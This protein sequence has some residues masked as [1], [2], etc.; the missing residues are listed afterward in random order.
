[1]PDPIQDPVPPPPPMY[2]PPAPAASSAGLS[3]NVAAALAYVTFFPA[4]IFLLVAPYNRIALVRFHSIQ[5]IALTVA[6]VL[7]QMTVRIAREFAHFIPFSFV[8]FAAMHA[9]VLFGFFVVWLM[10][11]FKASK[12]EWF[13]LPVI[14]DFAERVARG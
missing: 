4:I 11:I 13:R 9:L 1:M 2:A 5:S 6:Y 10:V 7:V 3:D 12:G 14:G 8:F